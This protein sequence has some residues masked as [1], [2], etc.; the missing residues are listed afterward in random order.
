MESA[1]PAVEK[2]VKALDAMI[3]LG[4]HVEQQ[5]A[6]ELMPN[7]AEL[8]DMRAMLS[9]LEVLP[10]ALLTLRKLFEKYGVPAQT[11]ELKSVKSE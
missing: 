5:I 8:N 9:A 6:Q 7:I 4:P 11:P 1:T 10:R 2:P 3:S